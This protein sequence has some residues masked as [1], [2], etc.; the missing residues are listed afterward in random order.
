MRQNSPYATLRMTLS[1]EGW[2]GKL[3]SKAPIQNLLEK[4]ED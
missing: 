3:N 2:T 1:Y 4:L